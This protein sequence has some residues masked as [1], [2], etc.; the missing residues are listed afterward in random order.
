MDSKLILTDANGMDI[1][2][3]P[4]QIWVNVVYPNMKIDWDPGVSYAEDL[5]N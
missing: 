2:F 1:K 5:V 4:G 3:V